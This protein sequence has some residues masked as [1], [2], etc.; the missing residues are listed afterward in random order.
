M[1]DHTPNCE[2]NGVLS[3]SERT[4]LR[5]SLPGLAAPAASVAA[6]PAATDTSVLSA[7]IELTKPRITRLVT[8]TSAVGF[9]MAALGRPW[10]AAGLAL[11]AIGCLVGTALSAAGANALNQLIERHRDARMPRTMTRPLPT[12]RISPGAALRAGVALCALGVGVLWIINGPAPALVSLATIL[13]YLFLYTPLKPVTPWATLVGSVPG[14]L[15][16]LIGWTAAASAFGV[17]DGFAAMTQLGGWSLVALMVIWQIPHFLAIAWMYREDYAR[18]GYAILPLM[19]P[20][21]RRTAA[22]ILLTSAILLPATL[23]PGLV[24]ADRLSA[25]YLAIAVLTG[26]AFLATAVILFRNITRA[27]ARTVFVAS[28]MHLPLLLVAMVADALIVAAL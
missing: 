6:H 27:N 18:G 2:A 21:G 25:V 19:D 5:E 23:A 15:P 20:T 28:I 14:A 13:L 4:H 11:A 12:G 24:M 7:L 9:V 10:T 3:A 22:T 16:P 17:A 1:S 8:I 26:L